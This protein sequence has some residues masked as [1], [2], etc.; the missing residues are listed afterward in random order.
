MRNGWTN[1]SERKRRG[2]KRTSRILKSTSTSS[3]SSNRQK[4]KCRLLIYRSII[5][6]RDRLF[7]PMIHRF[8]SCAVRYFDWANSNRRYDTLLH[9]NAAFLQITSISF[10]CVAPK[11]SHQ[12]R[13]I[14]FVV[15]LQLELLHVNIII[16]LI[17]QIS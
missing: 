2:V 10:D 4:Q 9:S 11:P 1:Y 17:F 8:W 6:P 16:R 5:N 7:M 13:I 12:H 15:F 14:F 3:S